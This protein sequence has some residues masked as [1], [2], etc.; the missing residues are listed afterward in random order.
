MLVVVALVR[1]VEPV[2]MTPAFITAGD[3]VTAVETVQV[4]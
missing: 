3:E 1:R 2:V 4:M